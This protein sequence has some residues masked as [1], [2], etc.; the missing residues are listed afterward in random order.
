MLVL[1]RREREKIIVGDGLVTITVTRIESGRVHIGIDASD[2]LSIHREE[3][4]KKIKQEGGSL[5][6]DK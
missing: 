2:E 1:T 3:I 4:Y 6:L 5:T